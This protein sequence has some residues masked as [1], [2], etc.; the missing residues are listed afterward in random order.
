M[1]V[2]AAAISKSSDGFLF[3]HK[4]GPKGVKKPSE[5]FFERLLNA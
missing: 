5:K 2:N 3:Y 4:L 1:L